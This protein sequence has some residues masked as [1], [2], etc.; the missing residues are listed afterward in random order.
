MQAL[1]SFE[2]A[3]PLAAP[4]RFFL[5]APL[6]GVAAGLLAVVEGPQVFSSRWSAGTLAITHLLTI[7]FMMMAMLGALIQILPVVAGANLAHPLR[8]AR[9]VHGALTLG[10]LLLVG[11][12][13]S[14]LPAMLF[15]S[16]LFLALTVGFFLFVTLKV[17]LGLPST[18]P[19]IRG[20]KLALFGLLGVTGLGL[21]LL[22]SLLAG[23]SIPLA[24]MV[25]LHAAWG[26]GGWAGIL[27]A[28][29]AYV[30]VPMFQLTPGYPARSSWWFPW[31]LLGV[32]AVWTLAVILG[33]PGVVR[34]AQFSAGLA[35]GG[36]VIQTL[37]LQR[38]RRRARPDATYRYWQMGLVAALLALV[39]TVLAAWFPALAEI[40][41]WSLVFG[42]LLIAGGFL[43]LIIGMLYKIVPFLAWLHLQNAGQAKVPAPSMNKILADR[44][45]MRQFW[46]YGFSV[47]LGLGAVFLPELLAR[48]AG[49]A[50]ALANGWL[51]VN[52]LLATLR[53]RR[54]LATISAAVLA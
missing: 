20:I 1:L 35:G 22:V 5:T 53:Y 42:I 13:L 39:M 40:P 23:W 25:D 34:L 9:V 26:L 16:G 24:G 52:L 19:T 6:F 27:L 32:L 10:T 46:L 15:I 2:N 54:H 48:P 36:F 51:A 45:M 47:L 50:F 41:S 33:L 29:I 31:V 44:E 18:S 17:L 8:V 14:W 11:G 4:V 21:L 3:P 28:S 12:L 7:G 49:L 37:L 30:V 38:K 43:P